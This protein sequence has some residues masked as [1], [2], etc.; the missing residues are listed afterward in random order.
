VH[1]RPI[2]A[3]L[4]LAFVLASCAAS[5][6]FAIV[7]TEDQFSDPSTPAG[8]VGTNNRLSKK[9]SKGGVHIDARGVYLDPFVYRDRATGHIETVGF[10][11]SHYSFEP[12]DGFRPIEEI[13]FLTDRG[14]R[15]VLEVRSRD[16]EFSVGGWNPVAKSFSTTFS[17]SGIS[18]TTAEDFQ[19]LALAGRLE[20]KIV[21]G[22]RQQT[23][24][25]TEVLPSFRENLRAFYEDQLRLE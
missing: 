23:Y 1:F 6:K 24:S 4:A 3:S 25:H 2:F 22:K 11:V 8:F 5:Q 10:F 9:S 13:I 21:G 7:P 20:A 19:A 12:G 17:E 16:S 18:F 14:D 15:I